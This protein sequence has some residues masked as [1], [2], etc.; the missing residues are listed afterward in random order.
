MQSWNEIWHKGNL[1][2][3]NQLTNGPG[4]ITSSGSITGNAATATYAE[5]S[6]KLY[7]TDTTYKYGGGSP[8]YGYLSYTG[9]R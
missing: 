7:S 5:N 2:N 8:Y 3:L 6:S 9:S 4:F 1:T